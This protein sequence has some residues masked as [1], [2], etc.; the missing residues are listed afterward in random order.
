MKIRKM[1]EADISYVYAIEKDI[2]SEPWKEEDFRRAIENTNNDYLIAEV[3]GQVVAYCG[4]WGIPPEGYIYNV[5][6][7]KEYR[8][9]QIAYHMLTLL[10]ER[11]KERGITELTLEVRMSNIPAKSLYDV[12]GFKEVGIRKDFYSKPTEDGVIMWYKPIQ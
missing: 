12:L 7:Q 11:A 8:K 5:A 10:M 9:Q 3:D 6:V 1:A 2:F 4:Y